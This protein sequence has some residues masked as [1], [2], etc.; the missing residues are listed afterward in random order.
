[1]TE[2]NVKRSAAYCIVVALVS[3]GAVGLGGCASARQGVVTAGDIPIVPAG[4]VSAREMARKLGMT[5]RS[6]SA[7]NATLANRF[8]SVVFFAD[9]AGVT[10]VNGAA[11]GKKGGITPVGETLYVREALEQDIRLAMRSVIAYVP[12]PERSASPRHSSTP[13]PKPTISYGPVVID[14]GHGGRDP[15]AGHNGR[16]EK[17]IVLNVALMIADMLRAS[18]VDVRM[19]RSDDTFIELNDRAAL[20]DRTAAKLFV[21]LHCDA[22]ANRG[23]RGFTIYA[24]ETRMSQAG[25][26]ASAVEKS[27]LTTG[28]SSRGIRAAGYR[29]LLRT[30]CPA[31]LLEMGYLTN[32]YDARLLGSKSHQ[33]DIARAVADAVKACLTR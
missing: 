24:P 10:Y 19:T 9:P 28:Q 3:L 20:A 30:S 8:N 4:A 29:V 26:L 1:M 5:V 13:S 33:R 32:R 6:S 11:V 27:M 7:H 18:N 15:G 25:A 16:T 23:A 17:D 21:S 12:T 22:A 31:I 14:A 2:H